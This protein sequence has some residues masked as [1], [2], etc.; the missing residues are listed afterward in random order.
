MRYSPQTHG[1]GSVKLEAPR[2]F[3]ITRK[4]LMLNFTWHIAQELLMTGL[5]NSIV[6][7]PR[8]SPLADK[9]ANCPGAPC[10][11]LFHPINP[12][13]LSSHSDD[14]NPV[15]DVPKLAK[16]GVLDNLGVR[17]DATA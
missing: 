15:A 9:L 3:T 7:L 8:R 16:D 2:L 12:L 11:T 4:S 13:L 1:I 6:E 17:V 14:W 5:G 10:P